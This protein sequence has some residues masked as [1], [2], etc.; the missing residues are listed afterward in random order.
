MVGQK[1]TLYFARTRSSRVPALEFFEGLQ[2]NDQVKVTALF[3]RLADDGKIHNEEKCK[4]LEDGIMELKSHQV[5]VLFAFSEDEKAV[6]LLTHGFF[7]KQQKT[8]KGEIERAKRILREDREL[9]RRPKVI[10]IK[11]RLGKE[12]QAND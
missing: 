2:R 9:N 1:L 7:K 11:G 4:L 3:K 12:H 10:S 5:R 8:P 6:V